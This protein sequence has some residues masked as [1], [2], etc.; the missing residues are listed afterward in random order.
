[1]LRPSVINVPS[2]KISLLEALGS[3]GDLTIYANRKNVLLIREEN[4]QRIFKVIDLSSDEIFSSP[5]FYLRPNDIIYVEPNKTKI[6]SVS[7]A[8]Q[9]LPVIFSALSLATVTIYRIR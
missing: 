6:S 9:W 8:R 3:A 7:A 5:Y 1:M 2:E 4:N